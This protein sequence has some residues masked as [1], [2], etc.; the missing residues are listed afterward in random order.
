MS[1]QYRTRMLAIADELRAQRVGKYTSAPPIY[2]LAWKLGIRVRP[3]LYQSFASLALGMGSWFGVVY[4]LLMWLL[5]W[6]GEGMS[7]AR[8]SIESLFAG[9]FFGLAMAG[10]YRWKAARL[11]LPPLYGQSAAG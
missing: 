5:S 2:R 10:Y 1:D 6:R 7:I 8:A 3:P 9:V 4:G 11:K